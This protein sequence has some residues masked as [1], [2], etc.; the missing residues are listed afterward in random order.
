MGRRHSGDVPVMRCHSSGHARVRI[1]GKTHWLGRWGSPE[2][3]LKYDGLIAAYLAS[4]RKSVEAALTPQEPA[5]PEPLPAEITVGELCLRWLRHI[6]KD[7]GEGYK[8]SSTYCSALAATRALRPFAT[9]PASQFGPRRLLEVRELYAATRVIRRNKKGEIVVDKPRTRRYVND[10]IGRV[11]QMFSWAVARELVPGDKARALRE[12]KPLRPGEVATVVDTAPR[13]AVDDASVEAV[14][15]HLRPPLRSLVRFCRL[16]GCRP[17]E[18]A[19]LRM[20]DIHDQDCQV[21][22][23]SPPEHKNAW[24]GH[25][26]H[27]PVGP[28]AQA[29]VLEALGGRGESAYVFDPRLAVPDRRPRRGTIKMAGRLASHRVHE[30]YTTS[31]IRHGV[32]RACEK[33]GCGS[34]FPY[35]LRYARNQEI[36]RKHGAEAAA[37]NL[38]DRSPQML[39]R[40][41]P[42]G[43]EKAA[44]AALATG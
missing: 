9:L 25:G 3:Q 2:A 38:G 10:T 18:A 15:A 6:Q 44:E 36:R 43:W 30:F 4:G 31:A 8:R 37:V 32:M 20:A 22:R 1:N 23:Y 12:V 33:A 19:R 7:R 42:P 35:M 29:V 28:Q 16:T 21:W 26:R 11:V 24:R 13:K 27:I 14:L 39:N 34:W 41:A 40:Y 5:E 17:G